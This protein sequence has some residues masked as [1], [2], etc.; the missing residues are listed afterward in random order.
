MSLANCY[1]PQLVRAEPHL[2]QN[3]DNSKRTNLTHHQAGLP[4]ESVAYTTLPRD[5]EVNV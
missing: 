3:V 2:D 4:T 1:L 5:M